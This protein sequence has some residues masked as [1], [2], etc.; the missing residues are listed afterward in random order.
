MAI[1]RKYS[2]T[3]QQAAEWISILDSGDISPEEFETFL[4]WRDQSPQHK[5]EFERMQDAWN[6]VSAYE[7]PVP[8]SLRPKQNRHRSFRQWLQQAL[9][10][11]LQPTGWVAVA[12][13]A[14]LLLAVVLIPPGEVPD[15][16]SGPA[17]VSTAVETKPQVYV[18]DRAQ[19]LKI[20]LQDNSILHLK[21]LS[22]VKVSYT[23]S[24]RKIELQRGEAF[25]DVARDLRRPFRVY[26]NDGLVEALGTQ[27]A[28]AL[29]GMDLSGTHD[30]SVK[31]VEGVIKVSRLDAQQDFQRLM[32]R[33][34]HHLLI[35]TDQSD[36]DATTWATTDIYES[37]PDAGISWTRGRLIFRGTQLQLA[38]DEI[39]RHSSHTLV[40]KDRELN[41]IPIYASFDAGDWRAAL[42]AIEASL[43]IRSESAGDDRTFLYARLS[44]K[45]K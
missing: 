36:G 21:P 6:R 29:D 11:F 8:A 45:A 28:V 2:T 10:P 7:V 31:L 39:N 1:K 33:P 18:A 38:L 12:T 4:Q 9:R 32:T 27:F 13:A 30:L 15:T 23:N 20:R 14:S 25:F 19:V 42:K 5:C 16:P 44:T 43:D 40:L 41:D 17:Q 22:E 26:A 37:S 24:V 34:G 3:E 35:S